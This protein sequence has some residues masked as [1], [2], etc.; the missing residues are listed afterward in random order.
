MI[1]QHLRQL[2]ESGV[3]VEQDI[4]SLS[5]SIRRNHYFFKWILPPVSF[6]LILNIGSIGDMSFLPMLK[7]LMMLIP[8][9]GASLWLVG[10]MSPA[11]FNKWLAFGL[12]LTTSHLHFR[13]RSYPLEEIESVSF[14]AHPT[15]LSNHLILTVRGVKVRI[16][17]PVEEFAGQAMVEVIQ[18]HA[19]LRR[20][21]FEQAGHD[22]SQA[23]TPPQVLQ[24]I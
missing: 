10:L 4:D 23:S 24:Q 6:L 19:T 16:S 18:H 15:G 2:Q 8:A 5:L 22:L 12:R 13:N 9:L 14:L 20:T 3:N 11:F 1:D 21:A 7:I 17:M